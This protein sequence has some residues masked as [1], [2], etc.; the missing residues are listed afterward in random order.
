MILAPVAA[1]AKGEHRDTIDKI[2]QDG[3]VRAR[4]DGKIIDL[5]GDIPKL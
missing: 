3:F 4:I 2:R 5:D 1:G